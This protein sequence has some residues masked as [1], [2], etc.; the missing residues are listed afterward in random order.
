MF[1]NIYSPSHLMYISQT[2]SG[3]IELCG[4][5]KNSKL[6]FE[7]LEVAKH[8]LIAIFFRDLDNF[9]DLTL[10]VRKSQ[11]DTPVELDSDP[12]PNREEVLFDH[13]FRKIVDCEVLRTFLT[14]FNI[15]WTATDNVEFNNSIKV[16]DMLVYTPVDFQQFVYAARDLIREGTGLPMESTKFVNQLVDTALPELLN[17]WDLA[18]RRYANVC[19]VRPENQL[20]FKLGMHPDCKTFMVTRPPKMIFS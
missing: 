7:N 10:M 8:H 12:I 14:S 20:V 17:N 4:T 3:D 16:G 11:H 1:Y 19:V 13:K 15:P 5:V 9:S 2:N 18:S 6:V